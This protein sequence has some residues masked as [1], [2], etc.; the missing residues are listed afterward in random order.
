M[1][2]SSAGN[3]GVR[4]TW[5]QNNYNNNT[6][7]QRC[8]V[9]LIK[10]R[11]KT[12]PT[13]VTDNGPDRV[14]QRKFGTVEKRLNFR[15]PSVVR[16]KK[17]YLKFLALHNEPCEPLT[18]FVVVSNAKRRFRNAIF[19]TPTVS[20]DYLKKSLTVVIKMVRDGWTIYKTY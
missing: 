12:V 13:V 5:K 6:N 8:K 11:D 7:N 19:Q 18:V 17:N 1:K 15:Q 20:H 3:K 2:T 14:I 9:I 16:K 4:R 10:N